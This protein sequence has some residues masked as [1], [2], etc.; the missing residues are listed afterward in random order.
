MVA[1]TKS[2]PVGDVVPDTRGHTLASPSRD[3]ASDLVTSAAPRAIG[4]KEYSCRFVLQR[5]DRAP[6][7]CSNISSA[8][9]PVGFTNEKESHMYIGGGMLLLIIILFL[10]LR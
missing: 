10:V 7:R 8:L 2:D 9:L 6:R 3:Q 1:R 5:T 4:Y